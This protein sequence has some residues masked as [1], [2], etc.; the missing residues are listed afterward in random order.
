M[1]YPKIKATGKHHFKHLWVNFLFQC[2]SVKISIIGDEGLPV[3]VDGEA[4]IQPP[5]FIR[6]HHKNRA[7]MLTRD[8]VKSHGINYFFVGPL[9]SNIYPFT[10]MFYFRV[11]V[12]EEALK[13]WSEKQKLE[14]PVSPRQ[15]LLTNEESAILQSFVEATEALIKR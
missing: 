12:F 3:Q 6:I 9:F 1:P 4:W 5:G 14:R 7:Q 2:R 8:K 13:T 11:Q 15:N 10:S